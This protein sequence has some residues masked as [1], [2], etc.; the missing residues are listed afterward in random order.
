MCLLTNHSA[1]AHVLSL[2]APVVTSVLSPQD[3]LQSDV[4]LTRM[5]DAQGEVLSELTG[6]C[7]LSPSPVREPR[8]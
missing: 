8:A 3:L 2:Q 5:I 1:Q 6:I 7:F 4:L